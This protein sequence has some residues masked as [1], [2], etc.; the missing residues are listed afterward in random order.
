MKD[1]EEEIRQFQEQ[2][3]GLHEVLQPLHSLLEDPNC[4][5][6]LTNTRNLFN[7]VSQ[8]CS[9]LEDLKE[10]IDPQKIQ[11][12]KKE[13]VISGLKSIFG[14]P[15]GRSEVDKAIE[16]IDRYRSLISFALQLDL[17]QAVTFQ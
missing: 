14:W 2:I 3:D 5:D 13:R 7:K 17:T 1:K 9:A 4:L 10:K 6:Y 15:L 11:E 12:K 16:S 8:C